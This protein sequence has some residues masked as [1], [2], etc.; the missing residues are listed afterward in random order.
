MTMRPTAR[1]V[2]VR[3]DLALH[4]LEWGERRPG[5]TAFVLVHGLASNAR[6]WDGVAS[7]LADQG[8]HVVAV[9]LRGHGRSD[10]PDTGY[11]VATVAEDVRL[12]VETLGLVESGSPRPVVAGQSWG[13]NVAVELAHAHADVLAGVVA[14]DGGTIELGARFA[15]FE[16]CWD[17]LAPPH[18][19][20]TELAVVE[21][22][23]RRT[24]PD[25]PE[26]G[27]AG[28][29][30]CFEVAAD[31][32]VRPWLTRERHRLVLEGLYAHR[33]FARF[34]EIRLPLLFLPADSGEQPWTDDKRAAVDEAVRLLPDGRV[35]WFAPADHDVHAQHPVE[36]AD[37][38]R[39]FAATLS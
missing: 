3:D 31:G 11:D 2:A 23:L 33:P 10:A 12:L 18:T 19:S 1:R 5:R 29:L 34:A 22:Y 26:S 28:A 24:H 36:V 30:A 37:V 39:S 7:E 38:L 9:D 14:V 35:H 21:G 15:S 17:L 27:I 8:H 4:V 25:W 32:T 16:E 20:G 13:G 6:L